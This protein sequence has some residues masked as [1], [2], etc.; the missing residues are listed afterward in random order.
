MNDL[1]MLIPEIN[2]NQWKL[3]ERTILD[4]LPEKRGTVFKSITTGKVVTMA[5]NDI[6]VGFNN[7][8]EDCTAAITNVFNGDKV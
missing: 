3:L 8:L 2:E 6:D 4:C 7:A 1:R 5:E